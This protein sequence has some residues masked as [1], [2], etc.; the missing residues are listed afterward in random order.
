[1]ESVLRRAQRSERLSG[2]LEYDG[3]WSVVTTSAVT[4]RY[5]HD[6]NW[7]RQGT[8]VDGT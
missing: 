6:D 3:P 2:A 4:S 8:D 1:M 5:R 7:P